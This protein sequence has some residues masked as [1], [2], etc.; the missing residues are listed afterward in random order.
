MSR[1]CCLG[2]VRCLRFV[3][4][5]FVAWTL[6]LDP[7]HV[8]RAAPQESEAAAQQ[9]RTRQVPPPDLE[10]GKRLFEQNCSVCHGID[11][12]G[13]DGPD[14]HGVPDS[15]G[16]RAMQN[17]VRMGLPGTAMPGFFNIS[18]KDAANIVAY[19]R[20]LGSTTTPGTANGD[21][22]KGEALYNS[23]GCSVCHMIDGQGGSIGPDLSRIGAMRGSPNLEAR[24]QDPGANLPEVREG[25][26]GA[27]RTQYLMYRAVEKDGRVVEGMRVDEDSF[28]IVLREA[29]GKIHGLWKPDLRSLQKEPGKSFMPSFKDTLSAAQLGDLAAYLTTLKGAQ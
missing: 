15:L 19:I 23:S 5:V 27:K 14:L 11:A 2:A 10:Q 26:F 28:T 3:A 17:V 18:E 8:S 25:A 29:S 24:L 16:D 6:T 9:S 7:L 4:L 22:I 12:S 13:G 20:K 1:G 21:P